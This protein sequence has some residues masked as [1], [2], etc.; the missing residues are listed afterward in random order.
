VVNLKTYPE[1]TGRRAVALARAARAIERR[2]GVGVAVAAQAVDIRACAAAGA[3]VFAQH[4]DKVDSSQSTGATRL[5]SVIDAGAEGVLINHSERRLDA[6]TLRW[7]VDAVR[8][9]G[10]AS[11]VCTQ[12]AR[13]SA[14]LA[15]LRPD[16]LAVE[17]PELIGGDVSVT[18]ADPGVVSSSVGAVHR[19]VRGL[20]VL[21]GAGVK[22]GADA[23]AAKALG[24]YG[25][26]VASGV[27][28]APRPGRVM[29]ALARALA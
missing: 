8:R 23:A 14:R 26:L 22:D 12:D 29:E 6:A 10:L 4:V 25:I 5:E 2:T 18:S 17:P 20:P 1:S 9:S 21:C 11:L 28:K 3:R 15:R 7:T 27:I 16:L 13:E 24:A 19:V